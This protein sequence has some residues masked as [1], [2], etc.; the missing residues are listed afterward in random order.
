[1]E[2]AIAAGSDL[3]NAEPAYCLA[4]TRNPTALVPRRLGSD[5]E[6]SISGG[7]PS[8][9]A[10][11]RTCCCPWRL[12]KWRQVE[13]T[14]EETCRLFGADRNQHFKMVNG[15]Q[16]TTPAQPPFSPADGRIRAQAWRDLE[17]RLEAQGLTGWDHW[18]P[19]IV[20]ATERLPR[21][22]PRKLMDLIWRGTLRTRW[23]SGVATGCCIHCV[24]GSHPAR[25]S[26]AFWNV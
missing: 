5:D 14:R 11:N 2:W 22:T 4:V 21:L 23:R 3:A 13:A 26:S 24:R 1:V 9:A 20:Q 10:A 6:D 18:G 7:V 8:R 17:R 16:Y 12:M 25:A 15:R 19:E